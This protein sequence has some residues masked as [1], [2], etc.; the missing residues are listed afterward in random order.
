MITLISKKKEDMNDNNI[1]LLSYR[2]IR[3]HLSILNAGTEFDFE[4][5]QNQFQRQNYR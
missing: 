5:S 3:Y 4:E 1:E 2:Y